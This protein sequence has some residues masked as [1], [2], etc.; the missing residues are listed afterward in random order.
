MVRSLLLVVRCG[1][2]IAGRRGMEVVE[3]EEGA[4]EFPRSSLAGNQHGRRRDWELRS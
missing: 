4:V 2:L 3:A 1:L